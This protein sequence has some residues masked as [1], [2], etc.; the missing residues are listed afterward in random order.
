[1]SE[2]P[3]RATLAH[4]DE[5]RSVVPFLQQVLAS[6]VYPELYKALEREGIHLTPVQYYQPLPDTRT[7][8]DALWEA[9]SDPPG[10]DWNLDKQ[11]TELVRMAEKYASETFDWPDRASGGLAHFYFKNGMFDGTD[12]II[13]HCM[14]RETRPESFVE[15][16][17]GF[18]SRIA[19]SAIARNKTGRMTIIDPHANL[20]LCDALPGEIEVVRRPVEHI[21]FDRFSQL[22]D[23]DILFID[24]SHVSRLGGDVNFLFLDVLPRLAHGVTVH[25]HDVFFPNDY[26]RAWVLDLL[27]FWNEQ[28]LLQAFLAFNRGFEVV[29]A[30]SM[31]GYHSRELMQRL[32]PHS[33]WWGGG[34]CWIRR[35]Q[36]PCGA[37]T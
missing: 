36:S 10:I 17:S 35:H 21:G 28:Y 3:A 2:S 30:N 29:L 11:A 8:D 12:A 26:P 27:R 31:L 13:L 19:A 24:S 15:I 16:G 22:S 5:L 6:D 7:L 9:R 4:L 32:F 1:M 37:T 33:P 25:V 20:E 34:S 23:G 14:I 18:S